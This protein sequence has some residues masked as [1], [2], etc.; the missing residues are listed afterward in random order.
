MT[1]LGINS[2]I[3][4]E[5]SDKTEHSGPSFVSP[6]PPPPMNLCETYHGKQRGILMTK[7]SDGEMKTCPTAE[8]V[9]TVH[10]KQFDRLLLR[11]SCSST[12]T[13]ISHD[14][15]FFSVVHFHFL[16]ALLFVFTFIFHSWE[17]YYKFHLKTRLKA[18][19]IFYG[20]PI[21]E[22]QIVTCHMGHTHS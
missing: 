6:C 21:S 4:Y 10:S 18:M 5:A 11:H 1:Q 12:V 17:L 22:L 8:S 2:P 13:A 3:H 20:K 19:H 14:S 7:I 16:S 9:V 15:C